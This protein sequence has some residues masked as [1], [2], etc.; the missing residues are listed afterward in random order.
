MGRIVQALAP[1]ITVPLFLS[2]WGVGTYGEWLILSAVP[3]FVIHYASLGLPA[4]AANDMTMRTSQ[5]DRSGA[6]TVFQSSYVLVS[7]ASVLA[8]GVGSAAAWVL[9]VGEWLNLTSIPESDVR[10]ILV[11][12][13]LGMAI[14]QQAYLATAVLRANG[15]FAGEALAG[16]GMLAAD[17]MATIL[18]LVGRG[19]PT[20]VA[21]GLVFARVISLVVLWAL[22]RVRYR[23]LE[24]GV[25]NASL[26]QIRRLAPA[27][28]GYFG[29]GLNNSLNVQGL[30]MVLGVVLGPIAVATFVT[31]R[32][33]T[34]AAKNVMMLI[35]FSVWPEVTEAYGNN[36]FDRARS[37]HRTAVGTAVWLS[38]SALAFLGIGGPWLFRVWVG[39]HL[40]FPIVLFYLMLVAA[41]VHVIW[42]TS[43]IIQI[44]VNRHN[45]LAVASIC[46]SLLVI[47]ATIWIGPVWGI[48][49]IAAMILLVELVMAAGV[50]H[51]SLTLLKD[52]PKPLAK[53]VIRLPLVLPREL[54]LSITDAS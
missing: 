3:T 49:A 35:S 4:V 31:V 52:R 40:D 37:L 20:A 13:L 16:S 53:A 18:V 5:G 22:V 27:A 30:L 38:F 54:G 29:L 19:G 39:S 25:S 1:V 10:R 11:I 2:A 32:T 8:L 17:L 36:D 28:L 24:W 7:I 47:G 41:A 44:A 33:L 6:V 15:A 23:W 26:T 43:S 42:H 9:P 48:D 21:L 50:I 51:H 46:G 34:N 45:R 14:S 12:L